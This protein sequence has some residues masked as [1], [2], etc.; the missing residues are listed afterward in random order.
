MIP[1]PGLIQ[2]FNDRLEPHPPITSLEWGDVCLDTA[3]YLNAYRQLRTMIKD[4]AK[5]AIDLEAEGSLT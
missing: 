3:I 5:D 1:I 4:L 2:Y